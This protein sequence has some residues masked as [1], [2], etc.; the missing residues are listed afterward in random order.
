MPLKRG[1]V[2][3]S[4]QLDQLASSAVP[5]SGN[6]E[7]SGWTGAAKRPGLT[8]DSVQL[9]SGLSRGAA[10]AASLLELVMHSTLSGHRKITVGTRDRA[11]SFRQTFFSRLLTLYLTV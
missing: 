6:V 8:L 9:Q 1:G 3:D 4:S 2:H 5:P 10:F 11:S 7:K